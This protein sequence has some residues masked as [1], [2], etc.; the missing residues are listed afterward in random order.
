MT[1]LSFFESFYN[2]LSK[3][4]SH[5]SVLPFPLASPV[6]DDQAMT[7]ALVCEGDDIGDRI[8]AGRQDED[9]GGGVHLLIL[10]IAIPRC[11]PWCWNMLEY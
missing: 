5:R 9:Q 2:D 3:Q 8:R 11:N 1:I 4:K 6:V 7:R 10:I